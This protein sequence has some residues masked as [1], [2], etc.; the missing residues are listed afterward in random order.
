VTAPSLLSNKGFIMSISDIAAIKILAT[1]NNVNY[2]EFLTAGTYTLSLPA[3]VNQIWVDGCGGG[4]GGGAGVT[5]GAAGGGG[6]GAAFAV[7]A[8][9]RIPPGVTAV[10]IVVG[11]GG[12]GG[13]GG[14]A[15]SAT[16]GTIGVTT[17]IRATNSTGAILLQLS[18]GL[19]GGVPLVGTPTVGGVGERCGT[20]GYVTSAGGATA[21]GLGGSGGTNATQLFAG[22][23]S[24]SSGGGGGGFNNTGAA[25][26]SGG[27][28][29]FAMPTAGNNGGGTGSVAGAGGGGGGISVGYLWN[30]Y[31]GA[32]CTGGAPG[33]AGPA[34]TA[35]GGGGAGGGTGANGG[36][37]CE[38]FVRIVW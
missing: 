4:G 26:G 18:P 38:G 2:A 16:A 17:V 36:A 19:G 11:T 13:A 10:H 15:G 21:N 28:S 29:G 14:V 3:G 37:G 30:G 33:V 32:S 9:I 31:G 8:P 23:F 25:G 5:T 20:F 27:T 34:N 35:K 24:G 12:A 7:S 1:Q 22:I 6:G